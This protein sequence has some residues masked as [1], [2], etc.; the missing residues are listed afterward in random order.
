MLFRSLS[1]YDFLAMPVVDDEQRLVGI[2]T[3]DDAIDVINEETTEDFEH[4]AGMTHTDKPYLRAGVWETVK[5][6]IPWLLLL[7]LSAT[8]T[9]M[10][11]SVF[12]DAL[13]A[14]SV[15]TV[16]IP[17]LMDT[18]ATPATSPVWPLSAP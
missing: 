14:C 9:G 4:I 17:M 6:R 11:L 7:M 5:S 3:I 8:F 16:F 15:L 1:R 12:E 10:V 2:V 18:G 13:A